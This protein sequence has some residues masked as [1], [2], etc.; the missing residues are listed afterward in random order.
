MYLKFISR[1]IF[2]RNMK[3]IE[4][5]QVY[6]TVFSS[7]NINHFENT[8]TK[9]FNSTINSTVTG[10]YQKKRLTAKKMFHYIKQ[11]G[12]PKC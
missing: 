3:I 6:D 12:E 11:K 2:A 1:T 5:H 10:F 4:H 7:V 8:F 9:K